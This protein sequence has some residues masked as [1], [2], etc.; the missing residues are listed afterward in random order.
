M[1]KHDLSPGADE[2]VYWISVREA[3]I[4]LGVAAGTV[5]R[6]IRDGE[7]SYLGLYTSRRDIVLDKAYIEREAVR[8]TTIKASV[9]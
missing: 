3:A 8:R 7:L 6:M 5:R 9:P 4:I 2:A 1:K